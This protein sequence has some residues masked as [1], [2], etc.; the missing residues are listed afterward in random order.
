MTSRLE[1]APFTRIH[2]ATCQEV[3]VASVV[4]LGSLTTAPLP[5]LRRHQDT[6]CKSLRRGYRRGRC[7][8]ACQAG[9][10]TTSPGHG[11]GLL[12]ESAPGSS[13]AVIHDRLTAV[14]IVGAVCFTPLRGEPHIIAH[15][16]ATP[17]YWPYP[18]TRTAMAYHRTQRL[19]HDPSYQKTQVVSRMLSQAIP[20]AYA[21]AMIITSHG[22]R[23]TMSLRLTSLPVKAPYLSCC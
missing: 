6:L 7:G 2:S 11:Q 8:S 16:N 22:A 19:L 20:P 5:A 15:I 9:Y 1:P 21:N 17:T 12:P 4:V 18:K 3:G 14:E 10:K 13:E 23:L